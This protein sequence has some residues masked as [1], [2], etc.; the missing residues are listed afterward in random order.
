MKIVDIR[1]T[2]LAGATVEGGW[3]D[4]LKPEDDLH[5]I[6]EVVTDEG[7]VGVGST[8]TSKALTY[9]AIELLRPILIGERADEPARVTEKLRQST[10]WSKPSNRFPRRVAVRYSAA[11]WSSKSIPVPSSQHAAVSATCARQNRMNCGPT[12]PLPIWQLWRVIM[13][14]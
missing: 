3:V 10:F 13:P 8:F 4:D 14:K 11:S 2:G 9:G 1:L 12:R 7:P 5:T 6:V